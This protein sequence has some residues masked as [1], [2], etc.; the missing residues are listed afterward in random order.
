VRLADL[1]PPEVTPLAVAA[2]VDDLPVTDELLDLVAEVAVALDEAVR[3]QDATLGDL[4]TSEDVD[5][6]V[7][8]LAGMDDA[9]SELLSALTES[10]AYTRLVAHVLYHGIKAY[11]LTENVLA[12]K[13]PGASSLV[14]LGQRGLSNAAPRLEANVDRQLTAF[15]QANIADTLRESR[16]YLDATLDEQMLR[17][18]AQDVRE[19][20]ATR[21]LAEVAEPVAPEDVGALTQLGGR[22]YRRAVESGVVGA[23]VAEVLAALLERHGERNVGEVLDDLGITPDLLAGHVTALLGPGFAHAEDSGLLE[24]RLRAHLAPFYEALPHLLPGVALADAGPAPA[25]Q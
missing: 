15:V 17:T 20:M 8:V 11:A 7:D 6:L 1:A 5:A 10:E 16:R 4:V 18:T 23:V 3:S 19:S 9:R 12:R 25:A 24:Q 21:T 22:V 14:R 2:L 13:I